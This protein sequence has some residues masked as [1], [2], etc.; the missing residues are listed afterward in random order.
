[1]FIL[2]AA[3]CE[4]RDLRLVGSFFL[5]GRVEVCSKGVWGTVCD[6]RWDDRDATVVCREL[7]FSDKG[8]NII[9]IYT[10]IR[11]TCLFFLHRI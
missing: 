11:Y 7:G 9:I 5:E 3:A 1:M 10:I 6:D 4:D 8:M 2:S